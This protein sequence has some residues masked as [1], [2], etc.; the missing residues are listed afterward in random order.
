[1]LFSALLNSLSRPQRAKPRPTPRRP[2]TPRLEA[3]EDR[4]VPSF[5]VPAGYPRSDLGLVPRVSAVAD[6]NN[7]HVPDLVTEDYYTLH[8]SV[9]LGNGDG[10]FQP[11]KVIS[12]VFEEPTSVAVGDFNADGKLDLVVSDG[13]IYLGNG[14]GTFVSKKTFTLPK[15]KDANGT[16]EGQSPYTVSTADFNGDGRPDLVVTGLTVAGAGYSAYVNILLGAG[17]GTFTA[18]G[19]VALPGS[20]PIPDTA[21]G[22]S[23]GLNGSDLPIVVG[24][25]NGDGKLDVVTATPAFYFGGGTVFVLPGNGDGTLRAPTAVAQGSGSL[26][27]ADLNGDGRPDLVVTN[28]AASLTVFL[29]NGNGTFRPGQSFATG[30]RPAAVAGGDFNHDGKMDIVTANG[31]SGDVSLLLGNGDGT[32]QPAQTYGAVGGTGTAA[33]VAADLNGDG[34]LDLAVGDPDSNGLGVLLNDRA[35]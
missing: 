29:G 12:A 26:T 15:V 22:S 5:T 4:T 17:R 1:M 10:T 11:P 30:S 9:S 21:A 16:W 34:W 33:L 31:G 8:L 7:D 3:L 28:G 14:D 35:W 23:P 6:F 32:F 20:W 24:D 13:L 18:A 25:F 27:A 19:T 2:V